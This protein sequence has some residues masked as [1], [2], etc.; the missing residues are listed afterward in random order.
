MTN[1]KELVKDK[2]LDT[3]INEMEDPVNRVYAELKKVDPKRA[4]MFL[5]LID[6]VWQLLEDA[7]YN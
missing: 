4:R 7:Q 1:F 2:D 3:L 6:P 5:K